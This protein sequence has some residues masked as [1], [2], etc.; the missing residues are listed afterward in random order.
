MP[1]APSDGPWPVPFEFRFPDEVFE[2]DPAGVLVEVDEVA[3]PFP[4]RTPFG[5]YV[6]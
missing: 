4:L 2:G 3:A 6:P 5:V 1:K